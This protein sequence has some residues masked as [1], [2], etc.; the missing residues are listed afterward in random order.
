MLAGKE[1][2]VLNTVQ[3][4]DRI[5]SFVM[6]IL[7]EVLVKNLVRYYDISYEME[8]YGYSVASMSIVFFYGLLT[9]T[10]PTLT[11]TITL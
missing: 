5:S 9:T 7:G 4:R 8:T 10:L 2:Y 6:V 11:G 1:V 3:Y